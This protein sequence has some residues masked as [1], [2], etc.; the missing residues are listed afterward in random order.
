[1]AKACRAALATATETFEH[2]EAWDKRKKVDEI[3][4]DVDFEME[5]WVIRQ[6]DLRRRLKVRGSYGDC[7]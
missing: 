2:C 7:V 5:R 4:G 1:M 3:L 6:D